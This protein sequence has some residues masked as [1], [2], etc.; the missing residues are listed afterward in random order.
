[1][2]AKE[3][4]TYHK[5]INALKRTIR[6]G[7]SPSKT[8]K[9]SSA[10]HTWKG[11]LLIRD[12]VESY[13]LDI[14]ISHAQ[15]MFAVHDLPELVLKNDHTSYDLAQGT[16]QVTLQ[17]K[18]FHEEQVMTNIARKYGRWDLYRLWRE[19]EDKE[20]ECSRFVNVVDKLEAK[21][22]I[23]DVGGTWRYGIDPILHNILCADNTARAYPPLIPF[24]LEVRNQ[25]REMFES[26]DPTFI[27]K[28]EYD[29]VMP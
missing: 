18:F 27:W 4:I 7:D 11:I 28:P 3:L 10:A 13:N 8:I 12:L 29:F 24:Y 22:H 15:N 14:N 16:A 26:Q 1:M 9:E 2:D 21:L 5:E 20:T 19:F 23:L 17:E 25:L 6:W